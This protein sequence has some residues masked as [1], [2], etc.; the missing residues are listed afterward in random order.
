M[1]IAIVSSAEI[2]RQGGVL[3]AAYWTRRRGGESYPDYKRRTG[4][5]DQ[6][7]LAGRHLARA[8]AAIKRAEELMR[9]T[10]P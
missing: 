4:A 9:E 6:L 7:A 5:A 2:A 1:K 3:N 10:G 8:A